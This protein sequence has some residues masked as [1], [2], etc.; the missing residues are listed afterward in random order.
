MSGRTEAEN[1]DDALH[2][3]LV[4]YLTAHSCSIVK[5]QQNVLGIVELR[6]IH[7]EGCERI[8]KPSSDLLPIQLQRAG[9][10]RGTVGEHGKLE[11]KN[12]LAFRGN[13]LL[14]LPVLEFSV[15]TPQAD[16]GNDR[17]DLLLFTRLAATQSLTDTE[18]R[19]KRRLDGRA[20]VSRDPDQ[21]IQRIVFLLAVQRR[22]DGR[23]LFMRSRRRLIRSRRQV[24]SHPCQTLQQRR[25]ADPVVTEEQNPPGGA[26]VLVR[27]AQA[28]TFSETAHVLQVQVTQVDRRLTGWIGHLLRPSRISCGSIIHH[29]SWACRGWREEGADSSAVTRGRPASVRRPPGACASSSRRLSPRWN[30]NFFNI[31]KIGFSIF[32]IPFSFNGLGGVLHPSSLAAY[33][34]GTH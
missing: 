21:R 13:I 25:L 8:G 16:T 31:N 27:E 1:P 12:I 20:A 4:L 23:H 14:K 11:F 33:A 5:L 6:R 26:A 24:G 18:A 28:L 2:A 17:V 3:T 29:L 7:E 32:Q 19:F 10:A 15:L 30:I 22:L 34:V 9:A